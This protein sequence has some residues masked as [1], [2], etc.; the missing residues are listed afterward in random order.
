[1]Q[2]RYYSDYIEQ[3]SYTSEAICMGCGCCVE[4]CPKGARSMKIVEPPESATKMP[5]YQSTMDAA[6][7]QPADKK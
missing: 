3:R 2:M 1:V 7:I 4:S 6:Y 5:D